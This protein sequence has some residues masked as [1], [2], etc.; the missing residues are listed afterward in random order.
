M[1]ELKDIYKSYGDRRVLDGVS[2]MLPA[3]IVTAL[4]G[5]SG[6]GKTTLS[7]IVLGLETPDGGRVI[8]AAGLQKTAVFQEDRLIEHLSAVD[9]L[10]LV[11]ASP[12]AARRHLAE[13]GL[14]ADATSRAAKLSGGMRRRLALARALITGAELI[15]L[16]EPMTGLDGETKR[17]AA[18]YVL[19]HR[20]EAAVLL[21]SHDPE[22]LELL[23]ASHVFSLDHFI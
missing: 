21:I 18:D 10:R 5:R 23:G 6:S 11:G 15:V 12:E 20:G 16:D 14:A 1:I 17:L 8:G 3:G 22:D 4:T 2:L 19:K 13:L 9:N 7:R